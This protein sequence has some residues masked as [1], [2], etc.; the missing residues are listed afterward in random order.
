[1]KWRQQVVD[2]ASKVTPGTE[3]E[4]TTAEAIDETYVEPTMSRADLIR[5]L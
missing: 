4:S 3:T 2:G 1:M 5:G